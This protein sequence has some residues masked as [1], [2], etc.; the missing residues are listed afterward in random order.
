MIHQNF[1]LRILFKRHVWFVNVAS[2]KARS[3]TFVMIGET[4]GC[5]LFVYSYPVVAYCGLFHVGF[6]EK[7]AGLRPPHS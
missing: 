1:D 4:G 7:N 2:E 6:I 5:K 3:L